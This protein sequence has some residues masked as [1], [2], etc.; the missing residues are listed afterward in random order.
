MAKLTRRGLAA[1]VAAVMAAVTAGLA[2]LRK[3]KQK[4]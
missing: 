1:A 2:L 4:D 3:R